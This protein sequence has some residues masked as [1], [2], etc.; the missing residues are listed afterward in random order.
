MKATKKKVN[1]SEKKFI[2]S[3]KD[4]KTEKIDKKFGITLVSNITKK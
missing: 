4:I 3:L 1:N 2:F